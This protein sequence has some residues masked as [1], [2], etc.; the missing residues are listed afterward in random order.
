MN[1]KVTLITAVVV[2]TSTL[3]W[4]V[5]LLA[6]CEIPCG[7]YDDQM[8]IVMLKEHITTI[9]KSMKSIEEL[10]AQTPV[11]YNQLVRWVNNKEDHANQFQHVV[12]Q[13]FMTQRV[14]PVAA[15]DQEAHA[16]YLAKLNILHEMLVF[17]MKAKQTTDLANVEKLRELVDKFID[18]YFAEED[19]Q[20]LKEHH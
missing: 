14:K 20:H 15:E 11:N 5:A 8:R 9:E 7:I 6:H 3:L 10:A 2:L 1:R 13:Y 19:R 18:A 16:A 17:T 4:S 12:T